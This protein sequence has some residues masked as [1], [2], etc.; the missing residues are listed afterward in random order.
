VTT[1]ALTG[2][3][4]HVRK[5]H[6]AEVEWIAPEGGRPTPVEKPGT[7]FIL[8][9][10]LVLLAMGFTGPARSA[11]FESFGLEHDA[12]G[13]VVRDRAGMTSRSGVFVTGDMASGASLVVRAIADGLRVATGV[14][15]WLGTES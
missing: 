3:Q 5:L 15:A 8:D 6:G 13:Q 10:D 4:G 12:R 7:E 11:L 2:E 1:Q 9:A 14:Q